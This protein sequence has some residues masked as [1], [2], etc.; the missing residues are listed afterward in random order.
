MKIK[1]VLK[2]MFLS[3]QFIKIIRHQF[4][5]ILALCSF[6]VS[7]WTSYSCLNAECHTF[8]VL[9]ASYVVSLKDRHQDIQKP[10]EDQEHA[11]YDSSVSLSTELSLK[12]PSSEEKSDNTNTSAYNENDHTETEATGWH[13]V[14]ITVYS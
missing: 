4:R 9:F 3:N 12:F 8:P 6:F 7:C 11:R 5:L 10:E 2:S 14:V 1:Y 13:K